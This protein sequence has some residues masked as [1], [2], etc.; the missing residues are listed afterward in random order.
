MVPAKRGICA[1]IWTAASPKSS[2]QMSLAAGRIN[3][4]PRVKGFLALVMWLASKNDAL[5]AD[6]FDEVM[7]FYKCFC[8]LCSHFFFPLKNSKGLSFNAGAWFPR[9][10]AVLKVSWLHCIAS[11]PGSS[12]GWIQGFPQDDGVGKKRIDKR[13]RTEAWSNWFTQKANKTCDTR[14][15]L[16]M[17]ATGA[18][19]NSRRCPA[20]GTF[21]SGS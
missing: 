9:G 7:A 20:L 15:A 17:E 14:F 1:T 12:P 11:L 4:S 13:E 6:T 19:S 5:S 2:R 16:T 10:E 8:S 3:S 21:S 18:R